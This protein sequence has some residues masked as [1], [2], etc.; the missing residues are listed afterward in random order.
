ML[1]ARATASWVP[2]PAPLLSILA[3][4][5]VCAPVQADD[6][7]WI[8]IAIEEVD[9]NHHLKELGWSSGAAVIFLYGSGPAS[10]AGIL[11]GD[12]VVEL[13]GTPIENA[14]GLICS[15]ARRSPGDLVGLTIV[16]GTEVRY[17]SFGL[18]HWPDTIPLNVSNCP[19]DVG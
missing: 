11:S 13:D 4:M 17:V 18:G 8:G 7:P 16:R 6:L 10:S 14:Q 1:I 19:I 5:L 12:I 15:I 9:S 2:L 3:L